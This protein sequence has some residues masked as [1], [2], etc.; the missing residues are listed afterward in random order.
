MSLLTLPLQ[1]IKKITIS[2]AMLAALFP[3]PAVAQNTVRGLEVT[4]FL[5][6]L[7]VAKGG[8]LKSQIDL[9]NR[10]S[11]PLII[12]AAP[13]DFLPGEDGQPEF[14]PDTELNDRTFSLSSWITLDTDSRFTINPGQ[15]ITVPFTVNPPTDAEQGTHYGAMLFSYAAQSSVGSVSEV[16]QSIGTILLVYY[17]QTKENGEVDLR[18]DRN[19]VLSVD[20]VE[21]DNRFNNI[22]NVHVKPKG[23]VVV[24][25][26]FGQIVSTPPINRDAANVLPRTDRTFRSTWYPSSF[27]FGRYTAESVITYGRSRLEARDKVVVWVLPWYLDLAVIILVAIILWFIFHGRHWHKRR[28]I[29]RHIESQNK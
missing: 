3:F 14:V 24:K 8:T 25:N 29:R 13:R 28:I 10:S 17:G 1:R 9:I 16:Q 6:E 15:L 18:A 23:E 19:L 5:M 11:E 26:M 4:P 7:D 27:S 22:G 20:K 2:A 12:T 21:F